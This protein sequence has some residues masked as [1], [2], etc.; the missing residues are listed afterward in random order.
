MN[1]TQAERTAL[2]PTS[3]P[4]RAGAENL[5]EDE[6]VDGLRVGSAKVL[7]EVMSVYRPRLHALAFR[8]T[9]NH[10]DADEIVQEAFLRAYRAAPRFRHE[11]S[12]GT[13]LHAIATN[14]ARN[15][16]QYWRCRRRH[17]TFSLDTTS[18]VE[19]HNAILHAITVEASTAASEAEHSDLVEQI[20]RCMTRLSEG[21]RQI[22]LLRNGQ[23]APYAEIARTFGIALGTVKSRIARARERLRAC[24]IEE[25]GTLKQAC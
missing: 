18:R 1:C 14:I 23:H 10:H 5:E 15:R 8:L 4:G 7:Q 6:F 20:E 22:L 17:A 25:I 2:R 16:Y 24:V 11:A 12:L 3:S 21:D 9:R 19:I 13:W